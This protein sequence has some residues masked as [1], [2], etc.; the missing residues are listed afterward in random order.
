MRR[1][2]FFLFISFLLSVPIL[3]EIP[4]ENVSGTDPLILPNIAKFYL[5]PDSYVGN[6][7]N[8][9]G[10]V[11]G[12]YPKE[13]KFILSDSIG[14]VTCSAVRKNSE[15]L[16]VTFS[17]KIPDKREIVLVVGKLIRGEGDTFSI[18]ATS[19]KM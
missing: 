10:I 9:K 19:V 14:C 11:S 12:S 17:G 18:N 1:L 16:P 15:I 2:L 8:I 6:I 4:G 3:A 5:E 7:V 13:H